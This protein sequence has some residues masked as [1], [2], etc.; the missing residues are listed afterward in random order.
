MHMYVCMYLC[1]YNVHSMYVYTYI[2]MCV[3]VCSIL[4]HYHFSFYVVQC[5]S[6]IVCSVLIFSTLFPILAYY[7][8]F[9]KNNAR[10]LFVSA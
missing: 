6:G 1:M 10:P 9:F 8:S 2:Y 4:L 3:C 7:F 5:F